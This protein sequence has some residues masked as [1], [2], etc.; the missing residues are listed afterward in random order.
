MSPSEVTFLICSG[1]RRFIAYDLVAFRSLI[2]K[3]SFWVIDV[4][5]G[6]KLESWE[7]RLDFGEVYSLGNLVAV[8]CFFI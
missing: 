2:L 1:V 6:S 3:Q 7:L 5:G 4:F 8:G